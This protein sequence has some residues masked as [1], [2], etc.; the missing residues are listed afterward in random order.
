MPHTKCIL[1]TYPMS[2]L[3]RD[4]PTQKSPQGKSDAFVVAVVN[5]GVAA[6][7]VHTD[8]R[9]VPVLGE[10]SDHVVSINRH[11]HLSGSPP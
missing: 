8:P 2:P 1:L 11:V 4:I 7:G 6:G 5:E 3:Y 9:H 10:M